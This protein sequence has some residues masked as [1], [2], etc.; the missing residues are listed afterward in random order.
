MLCKRQLN[1]QELTKQLFRI[2]NEMYKIL[3]QF[4]CSNVFYL[5]INEGMYM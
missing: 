1:S 2:Q 3:K 4:L 5:V